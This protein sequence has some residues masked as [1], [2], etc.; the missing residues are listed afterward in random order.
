[1]AAFSMFGAGLFVLIASA[2]L[3]VLRS[4]PLDSWLG[5]TLGAVLVLVGLAL[6]VTDL[7]EKWLSQGQRAL[8]DGLQAG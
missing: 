7:F 5:I 1:M 3:L 6:M 2:T 4:P 8:V